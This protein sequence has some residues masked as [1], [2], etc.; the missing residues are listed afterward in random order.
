MKIQTSSIYK[1]YGQ[2]PFYRRQ[3]FFWIV[4]VFAWPIAVMILI[5]GDVF[6]PKKGEIKAFGP[7]NRIVAG[8]LL[9]IWTLSIIRAVLPI[10]QSV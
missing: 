7:I 10:V 9:V 5:S 1:N 6:Y 8:V 4:F 2:V 3:W